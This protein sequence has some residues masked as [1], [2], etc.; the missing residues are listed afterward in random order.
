[1]E[2]VSGEDLK[3]MIRMTGSPTIGATLSIGK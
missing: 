3:A 1:M 2:Y